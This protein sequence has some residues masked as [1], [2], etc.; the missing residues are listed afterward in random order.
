MMSMVHAHIKR[1]RSSAKSD[2]VI[3]EIRNIVSS[4]SSSRNRDIKASSSPSSQENREGTTLETKISKTDS[5]SACDLRDT[6][7]H[8]PYTYEVVST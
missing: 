3:A 6:E 2:R 8:S 1:A 7:D 5:K 4:M